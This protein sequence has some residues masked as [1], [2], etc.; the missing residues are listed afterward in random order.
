VLSA[1]RIEGEKVSMM[2][3]YNKGWSLLELGRHKEAV[4][5]FT[6]GLPIQPDYAFVYW[7]RGLAY[8]SLGNKELAK[9]DFERC[10]ELLISKNN[11]AAA[12]DLLPAM[13]QKLRQYGLDDRYAL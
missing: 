12:G 7:R 9:R 6:K 5:A 11:V 10:A 3:Q 13:R 4:E 8:E 1:E 2:T